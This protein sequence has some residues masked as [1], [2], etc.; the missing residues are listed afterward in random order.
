MG[1]FEKSILCEPQ[2]FPLL[3]PTVIWWLFLFKNPP[4]VHGH[5]T[6]SHTFGWPDQSRLARCGWCSPLSA[7]RVEGLGRCPLS[8]L[9]LTPDGYKA[10]WWC[11]HSGGLFR[12]CRH[13]LLTGEGSPCSLPTALIYIAGSLKAKSNNAPKELPSRRL[14][15]ESQ[16]KGGLQVA[17]PSGQWSD[18]GSTAV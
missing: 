12:R 3:C 16:E 4:A 15:V 9:Q 2:L 6:P 11:Q 1:T 7:G 5:F 13:S 17:H 18:P 10:A 8:G 14:T